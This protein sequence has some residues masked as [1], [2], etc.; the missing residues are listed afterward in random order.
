MSKLQKVNFH[1][2]EI[3]VI[4]KDGKQYVAM[5]P[6]VEAMGLEWKKQHALIHRDP[7]LSSTVTVTGVVAEDG[8]KREMVCL[9][10]DYLNGWLFKIPASRYTGK[11]REA[12]IM[13]QKECYKALFDYFHKGAAVNPNATDEQLQALYQT[14]TE[15]M[16]RRI[17]AEAE[18]KALER[19][20]KV[21][22]QDALPKTKYGE[23]SER[24]GLPR[25]HFM[26]SCF[27]S[28]R[29]NIQ[30]R[31]SE[32]VQYLLPLYIEE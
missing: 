18:M 26:R 15:E 14:L 31:I 21:I 16:E 24:N 4:E 6:I 20:V 22:A 1:G 8:K 27:R 29:R 11:K 28:D 3:A 7:V 9:P 30:V 2:N 23:I 19:L 13:Y 5:K 10:L 32:F 12:I 17:S 25:T